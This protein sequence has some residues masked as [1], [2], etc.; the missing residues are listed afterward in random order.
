[1][2]W[3]TMEQKLGSCSQ[4]LGSYE[5]SVVGGYCDVQGLGGG[6]GGGTLGGSSSLSSS[7]GI[8]SLLLPGA[9]WGGELPVVLRRACQDRR[10]PQSAWAVPEWGCQVEETLYQLAPVL[11]V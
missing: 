9:S 3:P 11:L 10:G 1:M 7:M 2:F 4:V 5:A 6:D 8:A